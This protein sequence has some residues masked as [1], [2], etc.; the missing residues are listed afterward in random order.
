VANDYRDV[1]DWLPTSRLLV[2][3]TAG[4]YADASQAAVIRQWLNDGGHWLGLHGTSGGKAVR[5]GEGDR[6]RTM[7]KLP[8]HEVLGGF[9]LNHPPVRRFRVDVHD[10]ADGLTRDMPESFEVI[11]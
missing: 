9:F 4:P 7:V 1:Q 11:D 2:T 3:Y 5:R 10:G 8:H 6:R